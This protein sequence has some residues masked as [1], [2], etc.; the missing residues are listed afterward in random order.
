MGTQG[1]NNSQMDDAERRR[2]QRRRRQRQLRRRIL[3]VLICAGICLMVGIK[4][5]KKVLFGEQR[6]EQ[7]YSEADLTGAPEITVDLL[8]V[9]EYSRP[10]IS[11]KQINGVVIHYTGNPGSSAKANR[12]YFNGLKD[13][14]ETSVSSHF[15]VGLN[16]EVIQCIPSSEIAYASNDRNSDTLSIECC[17][18]DESGQFAEATYQSMVE[19]TGWLCARFGLSSD[20]VIRHYDVTGKL[21]P[22]YFVEHEDAWNQFKA[23]VNNKIIAVQDSM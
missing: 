15:I 17:H 6:G 22:K 23:D 9:N 5:G 12:N 11:L 1:R 8:D 13:S 16:G 10:G 20:D 3:T 7:L 21:C 4:F 18:P 14:H 2:V 19:L